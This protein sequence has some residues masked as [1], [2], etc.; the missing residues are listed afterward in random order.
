V[1]FCARRERVIVVASAVDGM[2]SVPACLA[3]AL[4]AA[5][6]LQGCGKPDTTTTTT[7][8]MPTPPPTPSPTPAPGQ[9]WDGKSLAALMNQEFHSYTPKDNSSGI[10]IYLRLTEDPKIYCG[11]ECYAGKP[12]CKISGMILN[13]KQMVHHDTGSIATSFGK[14]TAWYINTTLVRTKLAKCSFTWDGGTDAKLNGGCGCHVDASSCSDPACAYFDKCDGQKCSNNSKQVYT[15]ECANQPQSG[16]P[17]S[18]EQGPVCFWKGPAFYPPAGRSADE[19]HTMLD[20]RVMFQSN[21]G[22]Q[23]LPDNYI[24]WNEMVLDGNLLLEEMERDPVATMP[25][26][27]YIPDVHGKP[28]AV[29][30]AKQMAQQLQKLHPKMTKP[31]PIIMVDTKVD[32]RQPGSK[33]FVF[34]G[35]YDEVFM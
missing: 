23:P 14:A 25:A 21:P 6:T 24:Q 22:Q 30:A 27:V 32:A 3:A 15:C 4:A 28:Y 18:W 5:M 9:P 29:N 2:L 34:E 17:K 11:G 1:L 35:T 13:D 12:D 20:Q 31:V 26:I 7:T 33:P 8:S 16:W 10:G 19:T